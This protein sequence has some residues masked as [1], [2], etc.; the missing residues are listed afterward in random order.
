MKT[1]KEGLGPQQH[2]LELDLGIHSARRRRRLGGGRRRGGR[3]AIRKG[4]DGAG[5]GFGGQKGQGRV[6]HKLERQTQGPERG[7]IERI[8]IVGEHKGVDESRAVAENSRA[9]GLQKLRGL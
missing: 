4:R 3:S 1:F 9:K 6:L 8:E 7:G 5:K 2:C